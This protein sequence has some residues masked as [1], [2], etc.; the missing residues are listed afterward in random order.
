MDSLPL[1]SVAVTV[2][3]SRSCGT[4]F[5]LAL[6]ISLLTPPPSSLQQKARS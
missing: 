3:L 1:R 5:R 2:L 4:L 6:A